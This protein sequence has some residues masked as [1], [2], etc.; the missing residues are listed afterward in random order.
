M[1]HM[2]KISIIIP[3]YNAEKY[4]GRCLD[5]IMA[6]SYHIDVEIV[7]VND[8]STDD[9]QRI[10]SQYQGSHPDLFKII[11]KPN[12]GVSSARN[13]GMDAATGDW[14]WFCD[15]DDYIVSDGLSYVIDHF[16]DE[17]FD[18]ITFF[19]ITLDPIAMN[20]FE[21]SD[22]ITGDVIF[23]GT[24]IDYFKQ[25]QPAFVWNHIYKSSSIHDLQF[26]NL[27]IGEDSLFNLEVYMKNLKLRN[28]NTNIYRYTVSEGQISK[29]RDVSTMR[30]SVDGYKRLFLLAKE[31]QSKM[32]D[33]KMTRCF[34]TMIAKQFTPFMSRVLCAKFTRKEFKALIETLARDAVYPIIELGRLQKAFNVMCKHP[35]FYPFLGYFYRHV[36][37]P[38]VLPRLSRN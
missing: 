15:A 34:D 2:P 37:I 7:V 33:P 25:N 24:T 6:Q 8:G 18:I 13:A 30:K 11:N 23:E 26:R 19:S 31:Y 3:A 36:F 38:Y 32:S 12:G 29:K 9:T 10:L 28:T 22:R 20:T 27:T 21:E 4:I 5:S 1:T 17:T 16:V 14:I 35:S